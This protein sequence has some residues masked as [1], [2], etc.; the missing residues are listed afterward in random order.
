MCLPKIDLTG[1]LEQ[2]NRTRQSRAGGG[3]RPEIM[4]PNGSDLAR[5][6]TNNVVPSSAFRVPCVSCV[7]VSNDA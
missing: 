2:N 6:L 5:S 4:K 3:R 7:C 1:V